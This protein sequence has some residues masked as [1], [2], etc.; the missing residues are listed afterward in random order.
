MITENKRKRHNRF[1][2]STLFTI[3]VSIVCLGAI[4]ILISAN[5]RISK[6]RSE[7]TSKIETLRREI[8]D[9]EQRTAELKQGVLESGSTDHLEKI[10][11]EQLD[12]KKPGEEVVVITKEEEEEDIEAEIIDEDEVVGEWSPTSWINWIVK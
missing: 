12:L 4:I 7:Y 5:V 8:A 6:K 11:R 1:S 10:A 2:R 3:V 9:V